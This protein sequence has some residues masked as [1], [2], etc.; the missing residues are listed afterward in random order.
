MKPDPVFPQMLRKGG[1]VADT[2]RR[3]EELVVD[4]SANDADLRH[5]I[6]KIRAEL[7]SRSICDIGRQTTAD[8][9]REAKLIASAIKYLEREG[10]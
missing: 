7:N 3:P 10:E 4:L 6:D 5:A 1:K 2:W 9:R 8:K